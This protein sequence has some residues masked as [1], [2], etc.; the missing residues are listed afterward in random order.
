MNEFYWS[1]YSLLD[2]DKKNQQ[3][4]TNIVFVLKI[5]KDTLKLYQLCT[6]SDDCLE[7]TSVATI[8]DLTKKCLSMHSRGTTLGLSC[9]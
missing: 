8:F 7:C 1:I 3:F 4:C 2:P 6:L 5:N 9:L